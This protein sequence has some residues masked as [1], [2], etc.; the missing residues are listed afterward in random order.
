MH[1]V[2]SKGGVSDLLHTYFTIYLLWR[3]NYVSANNFDV[4]IF[5]AKAVQYRKGGKKQV[6]GYLEIYKQNQG[7]LMSVLALVSVLYNSNKVLEDFLRSISL[8]SFKNY[9]VYLIDNSPSAETDLLIQD[10]LK[11]FPLSALTKVKNP[12][13]YG[14]AKGNNQGIELAI[15]DKAEYILLLNNDICFS[16]T[17]L[18]DKLIEYAEKEPIIVPKIYHFGTKQIWFA[19]GKFVHYK[20]T[21]RTIGEKIQDTGQYN[22]TGY[23]DYAPTCF[24]LINKMVFNTVGLMDEQYFVYYDDNDFVLRAKNKG[25]KIFYLPDIEVYHKVSISTGGAESL[26]SIYYLNRN[27]IYFIKK[28]YSF[29]LKQIAFAHTLLTKSIRYLM[30][31]K[32]RQRQLAKAVKDGFT[33]NVN[34]KS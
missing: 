25:F 11:R 9:H 19:D 6:Q 4:Y 27:R 26:F 18:F 34:K 22:E 30:Y 29:P 15:N 32:L 28:H 20:G 14:V 24:M 10:V 16:Q 13:N 2:R 3:A 23:V 21:S 12:A 7:L 33:M 1:D 17:Y 5:T 8:Q 31:D